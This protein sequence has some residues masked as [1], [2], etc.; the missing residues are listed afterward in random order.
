MQL[1]ILY[2]IIFYRIDEKNDILKV[3]T[4]QNLRVVV[5]RAVDAEGINLVSN[6]KSFDV[7]ISKETLF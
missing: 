4:K 7:H 2:W 3:I 1:F 6:G 5:E